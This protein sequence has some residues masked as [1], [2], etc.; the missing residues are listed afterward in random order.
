M[1]KMT[2]RAVT[3]FNKRT[4]KSSKGSAKDEYELRTFEKITLGI[5]IGQFADAVLI[6]SLEINCT[7]GRKEERQRLNG[8]TAPFS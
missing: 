8:Q 2:N 3:I 7:G 6:N 4:N 1:D 5:K